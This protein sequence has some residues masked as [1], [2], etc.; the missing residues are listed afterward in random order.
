MLELEK[1]IGRD[2][3]RNYSVGGRL[4]TGLEVSDGAGEKGPLDKE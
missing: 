4:S 2:S 1:D 3:I